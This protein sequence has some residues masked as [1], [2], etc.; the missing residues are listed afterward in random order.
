MTDCCRIRLSLNAV[1]HVLHLQ[2]NK[3][4]LCYDDW[5]IIYK[6]ENVLICE[7]YLR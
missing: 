3:D 7:N 5:W 6:M 2:F 1:V 4:E